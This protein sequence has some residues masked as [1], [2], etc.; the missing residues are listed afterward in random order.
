MIAGGPHRQSA[1][2]TQRPAQGNRPALAVSV[3]LGQV[4]DP[5][6]QVGDPLGQVGD[7]LAPVV[8]L[9][10]RIESSQLPPPPW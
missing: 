5:L 4:G 3:P 10:G 9:I 7:P 8:N 6:G 1:A 2:T